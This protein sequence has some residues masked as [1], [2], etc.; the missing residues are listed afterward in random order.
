MTSAV[1]FSGGL[2]S[3]VL[4]AEE[5]S[6]IEARHLFGKVPW[7]A[8]ESGVDATGRVVQEGSEVLKSLC[9]QALTQQVGL[10]SLER[11]LMLGAMQR[12]S[13]NLSRAARLLGITR[14][15]LAYRLKKEGLLAS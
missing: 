9:D 13:G 3:A 5:G 2:D 12:A 15:Q 6:A 10:E 8:G 14:P 7:H 4:L 1:L 11:Q